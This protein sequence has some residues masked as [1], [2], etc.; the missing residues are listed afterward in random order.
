MF[1]RINLFDLLVIHVHHTNTTNQC[2]LYNNAKNVNQTEKFSNKFLR[3][4]S[5][6][7]LDN[8]I[9]I[10]VS[11][12]SKFSFFLIDKLYFD[13]WFL[14]DFESLFLFNSLLCSTAF[15]SPL[16]VPFVLLKVTD[17]CFKISFEKIL[18]VFL[19]SNL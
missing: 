10:S 16:K 11:F 15:K 19:M 8:V 13:F 9:S 17:I 6:E 1:D 2:K 3:R 14:H 7:T 4:K 5:M 18:N 12:L